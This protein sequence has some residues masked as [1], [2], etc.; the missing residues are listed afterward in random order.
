MEEDYYSLNETSLDVEAF[1]DADW[2]SCVDDKRSTL[3]YCTFLGGNLIT[4]RSKKQAVVARSIT[5]AEFRA[6]ALGICELI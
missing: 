6:L 5:E 2:V 4:W 3:G 1:T